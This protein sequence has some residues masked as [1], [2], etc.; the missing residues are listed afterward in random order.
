MKYK[1]TPLYSIPGEIAPSIFTVALRARAWNTGKRTLYVVL[2]RVI[3]SAVAR[4]RTL[5]WKIYFNNFLLLYVKRIKQRNNFFICQFI[6]KCTN[7]VDQI[8]RCYSEI[9]LRF[10][11]FRAIPW[12]FIKV[13]S[14]GR[15]PKCTENVKIGSQSNFY[16]NEY[17]SVAY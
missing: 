12:K 15:L 4:T 6:L 9:E 2:R 11:E 16:S 3:Y 13:V 8:Q 10:M 14:N 7:G 5:V 1:I 17:K